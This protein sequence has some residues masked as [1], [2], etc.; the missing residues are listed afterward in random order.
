MRCVS[1]E[2]ATAYHEAGH[3]VVACCYNRIPETVSIVPDC[4]GAVG[5]IDFND[6]VPPEFCNYLSKGDDKKAYIEMR[7]VI[8]LAGSCAHDAI[9]P[10][11]TRDSGDFYDV[12]W[13]ME[14][15]EECASWAE[16][17]R[18]G[19]L[20][21]CRKIASDIIASN[22]DWITKVANELCSSKT[23]IGDDILSLRF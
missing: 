23:L 3:A 17:D 12:K 7:I 4:K 20:E 11:R 9:D 2:L 14:I 5:T 22:W 6:V 10:S 15:I 21:S 1:Q 18:V 19:Y 13:A 16:N 8:K